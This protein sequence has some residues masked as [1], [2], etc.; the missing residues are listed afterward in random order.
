LLIPRTEPVG[1]RTGSPPSTESRQ[2]PP[3]EFRTSDEPSRD[4]FG[5]SKCLG[6]SRTT[7]GDVPSASMIVIRLRDGGCALASGPLAIQT[8][9][10]AITAENRSLM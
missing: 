6:V 3:S 1:I 5:A 9:A 2:R 4:Q 7:F 10:I 8:K